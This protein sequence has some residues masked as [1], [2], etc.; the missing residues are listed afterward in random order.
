M[1][2]GQPVSPVPL[3]GPLMKTTHGYCCVRGKAGECAENYVIAEGWSDADPGA[4]V[5]LELEALLGQALDGQPLYRL[6]AVYE[7]KADREARAARAA[8]HDR[9]DGAYDTPTR[10]KDGK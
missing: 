3:S 2:A 5:T 4:T 8:A 1:H 10:P 7:A 9:R 6:R